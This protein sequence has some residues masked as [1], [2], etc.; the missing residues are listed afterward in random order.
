MEGNGGAFHQDVRQSQ[1]GGRVTP[2]DDALVRSVRDPVAFEGLVH[3]F[4]GPLHGYLVR[5]SPA[6]ADDLLA[7]VW[8]QAFTARASYAP[9]R[10]SSRVWL[11]GIARHVLLAHLR[12][13]Y[14]LTP[15]MPDGPDVAV[16]PWEAVDERLDAVAAG[17]QLK[18]ALKALGGS[19]R[20]LLLLV[21]WEHLSPTE[22]A[23]VVGVPA[24]T[25][26]SRLHRARARM[27]ELL[28]D[29]GPEC[30]SGPPLRK[31]PS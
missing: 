16:D 20:E 17:P 19:E 15:D 29:P 22:A 21:A 5:R 26:R 25:A 23:A 6:S 27:R 2:D 9:N 28:D 13:R 8:L 31:G 3:A 12:E 7:Q 10:G 1:G 30:S 4:A 14:Q 24:G 11:F 18:A